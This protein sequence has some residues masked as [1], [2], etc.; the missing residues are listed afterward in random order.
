MAKL[1]KEEELIMEEEMVKEEEL[2]QE[3]N[4]EF[5]EKAEAA[6]KSFM[7]MLEEVNQEVIRIGAERKKRKREMEEKIKL[8]KEESK[9]MEQ[10]LEERRARI[11]GLVEEKLKEIMEGEKGA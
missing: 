7:D 5:R 9:S 1:D 4:K 6:F 2:K 8:I 3:M 10:K 11:K